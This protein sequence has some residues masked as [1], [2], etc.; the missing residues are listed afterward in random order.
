[1]RALVVG[2]GGRVQWR[3]VASPPPPGPG[4]AIVHPIAMATC[5]VDRPMGLGMFPYPLPMHFGHEC[6]GE[7]VSVGEA[8]RTVHPGDRVVVPFQISCGTCSPCRSGHTGSCASV[9]PLSMYGFGV[10]GGHWGGVI[11]DL[12][13]VPY[14]DAML[15]ALPEGIDPAAA[16]SVA[17]NVS[18]GYRSVAPY[19][20]TM[21]QRDSDAHVVLLSEIGRREPFSSSVLLYAGLVAQAMGVRNIHFVD[22][23]AHLRAEA[24]RLGMNALAP[25]ELRGLPPA[26]LVV[27][28]SATPAGLRRAIRYTAPDGTCTSL[29]SRNRSARIPALLMYGRNVTY[30][31]A[32]SHARTAI[33]AV[34]EL[35]REGKLQPERVTT[36][37]ADLDHAPTAIRGHLT[38]DSTKTVLAE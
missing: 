26:A 24:E 35:M 27:D 4:G 14:A 3:D 30:R 13:S 11:S 12:V 23:R 38:S 5:D 18:D 29:G 6:V 25:N 10:A 22:H 17:D 2:P 1:M 28:S 19:V 37:L 7:V 33:P 20:D 9:P 15:V 31:L 8:V 36:D 16:A 21:L 34:L 32:R